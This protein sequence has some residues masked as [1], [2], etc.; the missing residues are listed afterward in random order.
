[1]LTFTW[2]FEFES[3]HIRGVHKIRWQYRERVS[4]ICH[5][6]MRNRSNAGLSILLIELEAKSVL[7][8][9]L[10]LLHPSPN[11]LDFLWHWWWRECGK[12]REKC[13][14]KCWILLWMVPMFVLGRHQFI[15]QVPSWNSVGCV[16]ITFDGTLTK[17]RA[18]VCKNLTYLMKELLRLLI[19]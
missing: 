13:L 19:S 1:M 16:V 2:D 9:Y 18:K 3:T 11:F 5:Y 14:E 7:L 4:K 12:Y 17:Q 6:L 10:V 15:I 8:K